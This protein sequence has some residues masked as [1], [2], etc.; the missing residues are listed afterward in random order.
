MMFFVILAAV[1]GL[2][3]YVFYR[4]Y[5]LMPS[6]IFLRPLIVLGG[7]LT[8]S[9]FL[10]GILLAGKITTPLASF[11]YPIGTSWF[12]IM[13]YLL[14]VF[15]LLDLVRITGWVPAI[16]ELM[17]ENWR[18][19]TGLILLIGMIFI[20]GH[21]HYRDKKRVEIGIQLPP[22]QQLDKPLKIVAL[23]DLHLGYGI[24]KKEFSK[25]VRL[26]NDENPDIVLLSGDVIDNTVRPLNEQGYDEV[27]REIRSTYG[28]YAA[29]GNHEYIAGLQESVAFLENS[30]VTVLR[31]SAALIANSLYVVGRDDRMN[32]LRSPLSD[33]V[34]GLEADK[35]IVVLDHQ[36][37]HLEEPEMNGVTLQFSGHTHRG[38][39]WPISWITDSIYDISHGY[40]KRGD[41]HFY[42]SSGIGLWGGKFRIGSQSEY[43]VIRL[44]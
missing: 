1:L 9:A 5:L 25:W 3:Y 7:V 33:L 44:R 4:L 24:R 35:P 2:N 6:G 13:I 40:E 32:S 11:F 10:I 28:V 43:V 34:T 8:I 22:E 15:L 29:V 14:I 17:F 41:T 42:V 26:I 39:I 12:F 31:D 38:Q 16:N 18:A 23:S 21:A 19:F 27:F 36:P 20:L 30:G 37:Y